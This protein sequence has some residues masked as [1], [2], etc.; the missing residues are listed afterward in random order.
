MAYQ[1][2]LL[3]WEA[4]TTFKGADFLERGKEEMGCLS[5]EGHNV[6]FYFSFIFILVSSDPGIMRLHEEAGF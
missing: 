5:K 2:S 3:V 6:F 1:G 4:L